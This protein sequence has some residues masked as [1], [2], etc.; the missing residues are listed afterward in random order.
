[1]TIQTQLAQ[2][3]AFSQSRVLS[4]AQAVESALKAH[5]D[6]VAKHLDPVARAEA[7]I[8]GI[9]SHT[10]PQALSGLKNEL[11]LVETISDM[12]AALQAEPGKAPI[13]SFYLDSSE[14]TGNRAVEQ[15]IDETELVGFAGELVA[16]LRLAQLKV[17]WQPRH[18]GTMAA[19][20]VSA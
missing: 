12:L 11:K 17:E 1:M 14:Y 20:A 15:P 13:Y 18:N 7:L 16:L 10:N 8:K 3:L 9:N 2:A 4:K 6:L 19:F 5:L